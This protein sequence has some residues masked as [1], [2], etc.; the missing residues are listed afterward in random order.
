MSV[1]FDFIIGLLVAAC[2]YDL[3]AGLLGML[4]VAGCFRLVWG[5]CIPRR[6]SGGVQG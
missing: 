6:F 1:Y 5:L 2:E 4:F 3:F